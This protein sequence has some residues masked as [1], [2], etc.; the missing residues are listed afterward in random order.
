MRH[1]E[2]H[3]CPPSFL[4]IASFEHLISMKLHAIRGSREKRGLKDILDVLK[5][6]EKTKQKPS[7]EEFRQLCVKFDIIDVYEEYFEKCFK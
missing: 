6:L 3:H 7:K 2:H 5:L 4:T 1:I